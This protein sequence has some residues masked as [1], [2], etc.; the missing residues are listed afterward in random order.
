MTRRCLIWLALAT[1]LASC[2]TAEKFRDSA[3][4]SFPCKTQPGDPEDDTD[5]G[6]G[7]TGK[8]PVECTDDQE[9]Q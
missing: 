2:S 7:G 5:G 1:T 6:V 8:R 4:P 3:E 9:T